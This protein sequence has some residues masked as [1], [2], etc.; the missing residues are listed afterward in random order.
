MEEDKHQ[1]SRLHI[2]ALPHDYDAF[3]VEVDDEET[4]GV[5]VIPTA[6][7]VEYWTHPTVRDSH[8]AR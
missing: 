3:L 6:R 1:T 4:G 7:A 5:P 2:R 8:P